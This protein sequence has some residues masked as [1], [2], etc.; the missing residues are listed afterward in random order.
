VPRSRPTLSLQCDRP[1]R[2]Q[3]VQE[4]LKAELARA[5]AEL[6]AHMASWE[7]A[8][9]MAGGCHGGRDHPVHWATRARTEQLTARCRDLR[10][11]LAEFEG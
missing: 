8:F 11:R 9:A 1:V 3:D 5:T 7:Y 2:G 6:K 10:A 4:R